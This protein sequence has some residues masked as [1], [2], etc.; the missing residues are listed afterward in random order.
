M[1][2]YTYQDEELAKKRIQEEKRGKLYNDSDTEYYAKLFSFSPEDIAGYVTFWK[3]PAVEQV[4]GEE[5]VS[6]RVGQYVGCYSVHLDDPPEL[7][8]GYFIPIELHS[9]LEVAVKTTIPRLRAIAGEV[10][11]G[12][13]SPTLNN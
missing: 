1:F 5:K 12:L 10:G 13:E 2:I 4:Q 11:K 6:F 3:E 9:L 7:S 8:D